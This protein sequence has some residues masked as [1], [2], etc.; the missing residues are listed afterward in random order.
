MSPMSTISSGERSAG[1]GVTPPAPVRFES[2]GLRPGFEKLYAV[3]CDLFNEKTGFLD[4][5]EALAA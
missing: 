5:S 4:V 1:G 2:F 3:L